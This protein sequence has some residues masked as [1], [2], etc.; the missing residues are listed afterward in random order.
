MSTH[1]WIMLILVLLGG[2][3]TLSRQLAK[4]EVALSSK[5]S[6]GDCSDKQGKCPCHK[7]IEEVKGQMEELHPRKKKGE[8]L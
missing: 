4:I 3:W 6:Y 5:V 1:E 2:F 8:D 7:E